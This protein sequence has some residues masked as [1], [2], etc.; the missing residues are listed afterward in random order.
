MILENLEILVSEEKLAKQLR[1]VYKDGVGI[2]RKNLAKVARSFGCKVV[3]RVNQKPK[4]IEKYL[5]FG[6]PVIVNY[7]WR[8]KFGHFAV[9]VGI[10]KDGL[11]LNDPYTGKRDRISFKD[12]EKVW[13][14]FDGK[15]SDRWLMVVKK[16]D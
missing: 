10:E 4:D 6:F 1:T 5:K 7:I 9:V 3:E 16:Q 2:D 15:Y 12:F 11:A 14:S 8:D 13:R